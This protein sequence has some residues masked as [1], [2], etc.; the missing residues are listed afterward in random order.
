VPDRIIF[1]GEAGTTWVNDT[2][3]IQFQFIAS[4]RNTCGACLQYHLAIGPY[5][6]IPIHPNCRCR[7]VPIQIGAPAPEPFVNFRKLLADM[8]HDQQ[9]KAVGASNYRLLQAGV[10]KWD[11]IVTVY[12]VR[13][14]REVLA[15]NKVSLETAK[16]AGAKL[17]YR[18]VKEA[19]E[20]VHA[21]EAELVRQHRAE[22]I[23]KIKARG[24]NQAQLVHEISRGA[25]GQ[26]KIVGT[27][28]TETAERFAAKIPH[29]AGL[30]AALAG[31]RPPRKPKPE[32]APPQTEEEKAAE[33]QAKKTERKPPKK[34]G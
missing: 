25:V 28:A 8:P 23:E 21:P 6:P 10:V 15:L 5:W 13:T 11:E 22:L 32:P 12:R 17:Q 26:V 33:E 27:T 34:K 9:V 14:L 30:A 31:W 4:L 20:A 24:V 2:H 29:A 19:F 7:Q 1:N 3:K 18:M 16:K